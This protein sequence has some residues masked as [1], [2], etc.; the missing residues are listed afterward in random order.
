M[1]I[2]EYDMLIG[3]KYIYLKLE[4]AA[5]NGEY[6]CLFEG[7]NSLSTSTGLYSF[8][9]RYLNYPQSYFYI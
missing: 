1:E 2:K 4:M 6:T 9:Y 3:K 5:V 8:Y 7:A